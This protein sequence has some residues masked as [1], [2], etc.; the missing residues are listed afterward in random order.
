KRRTRRHRRGRTVTPC[1]GR[2]GDSTS[3]H[4]SKYS[5][6]PVVNRVEVR[7]MNG[8]IGRDGGP[9]NAVAAGLSKCPATAR[10]YLSV[11]GA[12]ASV[13]GAGVSAEASEFLP[14]LRP[15]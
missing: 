15:F 10:N 2:V 9:R 11:S 7:W 14:D 4:Y 3:R 12:L 8:I 5:S 6:R 13:V 1:G